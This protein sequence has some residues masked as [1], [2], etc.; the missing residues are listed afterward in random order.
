[1]RSVCLDVASSFSMFLMTTW[2]L[3]ENHGY[4]HLPGKNVAEK[5]LHIYRRSN[6][7]PVVTGA[8]MW[9][10]SAAL[11]LG[12]EDG[13]QECGIGKF[14]LLPATDIVSSHHLRWNANNRGSYIPPQSSIVADAV[15]F[16]AKE[17]R[18]NPFPFYFTQGT[19][20][21]KL[22]KELN[23]ERLPT[24]FQFTVGAK[25]DSFG[26]FRFGTEKFGWRLAINAPSINLLVP[27]KNT[28]RVQRNVYANHW[29]SAINFA[30]QFHGLL[31]L[32]RSSDT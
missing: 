15:R 18:T 3:P 4:S 13:S 19:F 30:R 31:P 5:W 10:L 29:H 12:A 16:W 23:A 11:T 2:S 21:R 24:K 1:M 20:G 32:Q 7:I 27:S 9:A 22:L 17:F 14:H 28:E 25:S 8:L 26:L 6:G